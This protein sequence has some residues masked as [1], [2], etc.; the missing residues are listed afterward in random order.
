MA[1][2]QAALIWAS[3]SLLAVLYGMASAEPS[4]PMEYCASVNTADMVPRKLDFDCY[5]VTIDANC[6]FDSH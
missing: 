2:Q 3:F 5:P 6:L 4:I 1:I